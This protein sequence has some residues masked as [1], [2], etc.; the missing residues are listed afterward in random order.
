MIHPGIKIILLV[1]FSPILSFPQDRS[2][3][4]VYKKVDSIPL[5][6]VVI[7]PDDFDISQSRP[8]IIFFYGGGWV[9]GSLTQFEQQ[10]RYLAGKGMVCFLADYRVE[11]RHGT[12]PF[13]SLKDARSAMRFVR[14]NA[15]LFGVD[16]SMIA[17]SGGSAGGHLAAALALIDDYH[18]ET[19]E[20]SVSTRP[21]ALVLFN[22]VLDNG[23][24]GY[25]YDRIGDAY[26]SFSPFHNIKPGAPPAIIL[27]GSDDNLILATTLQQ[28]CSL[29]ETAG[30]HCE[31]HLFAGQGHGFFNYRFP[32]YYQRT[33]QKTEQFLVELG[34][35]DK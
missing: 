13:E 30:N 10:A 14:A 4:V 16:P 32:E 20:P 35:I 26:H 25:G 15:K 31:L 11:S 1:L 22:P 12:T 27:S 6:M 23:P 24:G 7:Y 33:L 9:R 5:T 28:F 29:M 19:D 2:L 18:E 34:F 8:G 3:E 17:A 21:D